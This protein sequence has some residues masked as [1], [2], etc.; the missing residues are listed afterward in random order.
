MTELPVQ[1]LSGP[2]GVDSK[3]NKNKSNTPMYPP[4]RT[5]SEFL[6][7][8]RTPN[9]VSFSLSHQDSLGGCSAWRKFDCKKVSR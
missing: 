6:G 1:A 4:P 8:A 2:L 3:N 9:D 7:E 5:L